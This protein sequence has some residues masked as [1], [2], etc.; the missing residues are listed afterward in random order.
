VGEQSLP[1][2]EFEL[3][4]DIDNKYKENV[5]VELLE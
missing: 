2:P 1:H 3:V 5:E 4:H